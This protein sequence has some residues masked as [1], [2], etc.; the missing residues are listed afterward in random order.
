M[1]GLILLHFLLKNESD[2]NNGHYSAP[3][4]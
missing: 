2:Q 3:A 1:Q 4:Y